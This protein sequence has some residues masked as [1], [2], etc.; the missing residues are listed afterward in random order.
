MVAALARQPAEFDYRLFV[1]GADQLPPLPGSNFRWCPTRVSP[2]WLARIWGRAR[3]PLPVEVFTGTIDLYHATDFVLPPTRARHT[4]LTVHDLSFVRVPETASPGLKA[5]LDAAVPR[6]V[7]RADHILANSQATKDDLVT[8]YGTSADKITVLLSGVD[9]R[10]QPTDDPVVRQK[11]ALPDRPYLFSV[12]TVQPRK[13]YIRLIQALAALRQQ[14]HDLD[15][16]IAGGKGW[17]DDP[18]HAAIQSLKLGDHVHLIG[19]ADDI[20]LPALYSAALITAVPSLYEGFGIP[21]LESMACGTPVVTSTVSS[22]PE[23]AGDA[24]LM[25]D[26]TNL[27]ALIAALDRL[28]S[29]ETLRHDLTTRGLVRART[30]TWER[31]AQQLNDLYRRLLAS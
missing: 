27:D 17:L 20:D 9:A 6:S 12:G 28:I 31:S 19:F 14:G 3:L 11:Y 23:V 24:A 26:P 18:I 29:S 5:Y 30:F 15:L 25:V 21:V 2:R 22:L 10:F 1:S 13:N 16:V 8:L 7:R 4:L